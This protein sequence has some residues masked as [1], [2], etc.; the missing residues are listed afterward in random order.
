MNESLITHSP[1]GTLIEGPDG[2]RMVRAYTLWS[3]LKLAKHGIMPTR[4]M[5]RRHLLSLATE[6]TGKAYT[7]S[8]KSLDEAIPAVKIWAD[9][10]RAA[11]PHEAKS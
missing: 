4:G 8:E 2:I 6:F 7:N 5:T 9:E 1:S 11:I 3:A 10:M